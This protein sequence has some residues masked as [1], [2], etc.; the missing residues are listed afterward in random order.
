M[1]PKLPLRGV[2]A[3]LLAAALVADVHADAVTDWNAKAGAA[4]VE[5]KLGTP[6]AVRVMALVQSAAYEAA[7]AANERNASVDAA[8][9]AA[10]RATLAA[11]IPSTRASVD[12][13]YASALAKIADGPAKT[14]GVATGESAAAA[15]LAARNETLGVDGYRPHAVAGVYVPTA[16]PAATQWPQRRPWVM[17]SP[18]QFRPSAPPALSSATWARDYNEIRVLGSKDSTVRTA[19]QTEIAR[20]WE[21]S[22]PSIYFDVVRSVADMPSRTPLQNARLYAAAAQ[23]MDDALIAVFDAKYHYNFWRPATAIRNG[24]TDGND[25]TERDANWAPLIPTPLHPEYPSAHAILASSVGEV[26]RAE[27]GRAPMPELATSSATAKGTVRRWKSIEAFTKEVAD[28]RVYEGVH[29]RT[30]SEVGAA[31]GTKI[32]ALV[33]AKVLQSGD[34]AARVPEALRPDANE[35]LA[36]VVPARGVQIYECRVDNG[37]AKWAFVAPDAELYDASGKR[38]GRHYAGPHWEADDGSRF[39]ARLKARADAPVA[40]SIPWLLLAATPMSKSG[41]FANVT[42]VQRLNTVGGIAPA[43]GCS[44]ATAGAK[45]RVAY[46]ADYVMFARR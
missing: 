33:A 38:I 39:V 27:V 30:S 32:G 43:D 35:V 29:Y 28:A 11:L 13:A 2:A 26:L 40:D 22:L 21:F 16:T 3:A 36:A 7:R 44:R 34:A 6:P 37:E 17:A 31:M 12:A 18:S 45:A 8:I 25:A 14:A 1:Q 5:G 10:N 15:V 23:A 20:F 4:I 24:D 19:E 46:T 41:A 9:A 42:S